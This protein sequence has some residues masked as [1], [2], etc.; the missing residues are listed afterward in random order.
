L[1]QYLAEVPGTR[2]F[3][4]GR[5]VRNIFEAA[6]ARQAS[7]IVTTNCSDLTRLTAADLGLPNPAPAADH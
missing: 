6:L 2:K 3:G 7:R 4:N 1:R 5:L